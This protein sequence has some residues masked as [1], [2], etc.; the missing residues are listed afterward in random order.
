MTNRVRS[1]RDIA[2][3]ALAERDRLAKALNSC[4][5]AYGLRSIRAHEAEDAL[6]AERDQLLQEVMHDDEHRG[7]LVERLKKAEAE[8]DRLE[9]ALR[10]VAEW[11]ENNS[12]QEHAPLS[13]SGVVEFARAE[14]KEKSS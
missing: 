6:K 7:Q 1:D 10:A 14:L 9:E 3:D 11:I 5:R 2:L 8:R 12:E 13:D 4:Q